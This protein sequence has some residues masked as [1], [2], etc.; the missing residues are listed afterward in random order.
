MT[1]SRWKTSSSDFFQKSHVAVHGSAQFI[2][3][4]EQHCHGVA[5]WPARVLGSP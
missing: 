5:I 3:Y 2:V 4:V 1:K